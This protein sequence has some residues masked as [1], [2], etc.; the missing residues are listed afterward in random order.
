MFFKSSGPN[1]K[2]YF[3]NYYTAV[4]RMS[5]EI[6][7]KEKLVLSI[8]YNNHMLIQHGL[9]YKWYGF[10]ANY[11]L[12]FLKSY[13]CKVDIFEIGRYSRKPSIYYYSMTLMYYFSHC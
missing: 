11:A 8:G 9:V 10:C 6:T 1:Q 5:R 2:K 4:F 13:F 12:V 7:F 3:L